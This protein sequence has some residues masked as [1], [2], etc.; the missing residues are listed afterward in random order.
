MNQVLNET[1]RWISCVSIVNR[2]LCLPF[3]FI[4]FFVQPT[5]AQQYTRGIGVYPGDPKENFAP[6]LKIDAAHIRNLAQHRPAYQSSAYDYN[7][8]VSCITDGINDAEMPGWIV[9][10]TSSQGILGRDGR[11][12]VLDRHASSQQQIQGANAWLQI[13]MAGNYF[14]P[15]V[16][17]INLTGS[18]AIDTAIT[19]PWSITV[20]GSDDGQKWEE[21]GKVSGEGLP[22]GDGMA[23]FLK[24]FP[25]Q[26]GQKMS[27]ENIKLWF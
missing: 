6:I 5:N 11:E 1:P 16:D 13:Q 8:A 19:Q 3:L 26:A 9:T 17:S 21:L 25:Q 27:P 18:I 15:P 4:L 23:Q 20:S 22:G 2:F 14:I 7:L 10:S 12:H 24:R